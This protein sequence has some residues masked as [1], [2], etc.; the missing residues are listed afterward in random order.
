MSRVHLITE[1]DTRLTIQEF[2]FDRDHPAHDVAKRILTGQGNISAFKS[3]SKTGME[4]VL[5]M[6]WLELGV[7]PA[8]VASLYQPI[9]RDWDQVV[10]SAK[11]VNAIQ[12]F[13][14][15]KRA[16]LL[17]EF[18]PL[19]LPA[20]ESI[21]RGWFVGRLLGLITDPTPST[22]PHVHTRDEFGREKIVAFPWPLLRHGQCPDLHDS[23]YRGEWL[24]ALL[25]HLPLAMMMLSQDELA[26]GAYEE[27]VRLG[28]HAGG[29]IRQFI[30]QGTTASSNMAQ[31]SGN[32]QDERQIAFK[33]A[34]DDIRQGY[35]ELD[36]TAAERLSGDHRAF[37]AIPF[38]HE[39]FPVYCSILDDL[40][41]IAEEIRLSRGF[42]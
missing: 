42:G 36:E 22:G 37:R 1:L 39:L 28:R 33:E 11:P 31:V 6:R 19:Q 7:H 40:H 20:T 25:E 3:W 17:Q 23:D 5:I 41:R 34:I 21:V 13:W 12:A 30:T 26:L 38:G 27:T 29:A 10:N 9:V 4:S 24:P 2:P 32:T 15:N 16:R 18:I 14:N 8:V 35:L